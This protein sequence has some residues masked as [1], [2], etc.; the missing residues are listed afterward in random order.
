MAV[1][2]FSLLGKRLSL[3]VRQ[4]CNRSATMDK[5]EILRSIHHDQLEYIQR[6]VRVDFDNRL[7]EPI[8]FTLAGQTHLINEII[9]QFKMFADQ[10]PNSYLI[11]GTDRNIF[12]LYYQLEGVQRRS[13]IEPGFWVLCF[14]ILNDN[15]L[16]SW[17]LEDRKMLVNMTLKRV[18]DF[19]DIFVRNW[20]WAANSASLS[21]LCWKKELSR[22]RAFP[23]SPKTPHQPWMPS[24]Y[25]SA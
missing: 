13:T 9:G 4:P 1:S 6:K 11:E 25:S 7:Q 23:L 21:N 2:S 16:M 15:E 19:M 22:I 3:S 14:R 17:Y 24:R 8:S 10:P 20:P 18:A 12:Y 5:T